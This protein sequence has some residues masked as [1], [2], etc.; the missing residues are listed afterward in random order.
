MSDSEH[1]A[2]ILGKRARNVPN[3]GISEDAEMRPPPAMQEDDDESG[4][5]VGPMPMPEGAVD[6]VVTKKKRKGVLRIITRGSIAVLS[7][8]PTLAL[9]LPHERLFLDHLPSA[10]RYYKS[11]MHRDVI[12]FV[13]VTRC[14]CSRPR[15]QGPVLAYTLPPPLFQH[16][17]HH[18]D[19]CRWPSQVVEETGHG[20]RVRQALSCAYHAHRRCVC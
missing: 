11:F 20:H 1:D 3:A 7:R 5:D 19:F 13:V 14:A 17:L 8:V 9:V 15:S 18:Y 6:N 2:S 4:D 12:N 10:D 16:G